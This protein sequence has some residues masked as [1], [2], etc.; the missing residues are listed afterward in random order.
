MFDKNEMKKSSKNPKKSAAKMSVFIGNPKK[1]VLRIRIRHFMG[2]GA[3]NTYILTPFNF[4]TD[5]NFFSISCRLRSLIAP[6]KKWIWPG[7][8]VIKTVRF[9]N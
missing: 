4:C 8:K 6:R 3:S 1:V 5:L 7:R 2:G 9:K